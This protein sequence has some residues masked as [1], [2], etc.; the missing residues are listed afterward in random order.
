VTEIAPGRLVVVGTGIRT[1]G[2]LTVEAIAWMKVAD[3]LFHLV[4]DP[5]AIEVVRECRPDG[6]I[7]LRQFYGEGRP[8]RETYEAMTDAIIEA[9]EAGNIVCVAFY[10][11]PGVFARTPH[12]AIRRARALGCRAEM[13]PAVSAA[14]CLYA[15][16]LVDPGDG[17]LQYEA[18]N[19]LLHDHQVDTSAHLILWQIGM[20]GD[21]THRTVRNPAHNLQLLVEKLLNWY[22]PD[23][24]VVV[25]QASVHLDTP[26]RADQVRLEDLPVTPVGPSCTLHVPPARPLTPDPTYFDRLERFD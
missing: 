4:A 20:L 17:C 3:V 2:Q 9:V 22:S 7:D 13:L 16:L 19:F 15:E 21:W 10:G 23:H 1:T 24:L 26:A 8:R 6:G 18:T 12:Q 11:H 5:V 25:Y 14:S